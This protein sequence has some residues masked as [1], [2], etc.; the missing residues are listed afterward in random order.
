MASEITLFTDNI[1]EDGSVTVTGSPDSGYPEERLWDRN[2]SLFWLVSGTQA[3]VI[4]VDQGATGNVAVD[5]LAIESHNFD[6]ETIGWQYSA[7]GAWGGEETNAVAPFVQSGNGQIIKEL[8]A[9]V[10]SRYWRTT[11]TSMSGPTASEVF[12][13]LGNTFDI[14]YS[15]GPNVSAVAN[16][17]WRR[18]VGG[19]DRSTKFGIARKTRAYQMLLDNDTDLATFRTAINDLSDY[20]KQFYLKDHENNYWF[21]RLGPVPDEAWDNV[22]ASHV[23]IDVIEAL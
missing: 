15:P 16:V 1:L 2:I 5:F 3:T 8:G 17:T 23:D 18:T 12:M 10:T 14:L 9:P 20:S 11:I 4:E 7:T 22:T 6:G 13:G 21:A 19:P